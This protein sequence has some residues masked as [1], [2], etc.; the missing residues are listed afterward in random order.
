MRKNEG[1]GEQ[2]GVSIL[3]I[4]SHNHRPQC[5][6]KVTLQHTGLL[7]GMSERKL[8]REGNENILPALIS[9]GSSLDERPVNI[10]PLSPPS[11][12][13]SIFLSLS[14]LPQDLFGI[15]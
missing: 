4:D 15:C 12:V 8:L 7:E 13:L 10:L 11:L 9:A 2:K 1:R 6:K 5:G 14:L 3:Q